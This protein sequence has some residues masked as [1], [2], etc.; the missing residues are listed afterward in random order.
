MS[1]SS[2]LCN[3]EEKVRKIERLGSWRK[4]KPLF[5]VLFASVVRWSTEG[6][7][8]EAVASW[9]PELVAVIN[10]V[11]A[12]FVGSEFGKFNPSEEVSECQVT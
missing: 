9:W 1:G 7:E 2:V 8:F 5:S 3:V 4:K 12:N 11:N 10:K 6:S